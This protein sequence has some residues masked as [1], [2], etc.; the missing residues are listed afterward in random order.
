MFF[1]M[2]ELVCCQIVSFLRVHLQRSGEDSWFAHVSA[3]TTRVGLPW[4]ILYP[5]YA[6]NV[7]VSAIIHNHAFKKKLDPPLKGFS[8]KSPSQCDRCGGA[9][10]PSNRNC[11]KPGCIQRLVRAEIRAHVFVNTPAVVPRHGPGLCVV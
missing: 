9:G 11:T 6:C 8:C 4:T 5:H 7:G 3:C 1:V 2:W 10:T